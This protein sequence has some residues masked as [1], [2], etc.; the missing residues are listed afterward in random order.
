MITVVDDMFSL[1]LYNVRGGVS[2]I[3][4][5]GGLWIFF[6]MRFFLVHNLCLGSERAGRFLFCSLWFYVRGPG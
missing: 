5:G 4:D 1:L 6:R 2:G 3:N